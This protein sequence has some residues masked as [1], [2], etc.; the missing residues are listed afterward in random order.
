MPRV[1]IACILLLAAQVSTPQCGET[2][3]SPS[4]PSSP[5]TST[6]SPTVDVAAAPNVLAIAV[7]GGPTNSAL[8]QVFATVTICVPGTSNCQAI[9]NILVDTGSIGLRILSSALTL[10]LPQQAGPS[11]A[12]IVECHPFVDGVTWG[13]VQTAD[14][15]LS[16]E[17]ASSVPIQVLG[18]DAFP[19][20]P[21]GCSSQGPPEETQSDL[22]ANGF[23]GVGMLK[24]DCGTPCTF[25]GSSNPGLYYI[26]PTPS[27]CQ[28]T[29]EPVTSQVQNPVALFATDN[30]GVVVRL[31]IVP[32]GGA[33]SAF[34]SLIFGIGTQS[35]NQLGSAT[36][37][38]VDARQNFVTTF[39]GQSY[40]KSFID[41]GS[42]AIF[43]LDSATSGLQAC[44][45]SIGF[46]CP[47]STRALSATHVG[48]NGVS[49]V[50]AINAGDVDERNATFSAFGE[51]TGANPGGFDWGL[52][53]FYGRTIFTAIEGQPTPAGA[54]P[55]WAY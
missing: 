31:P 52:P 22:A 37:F 26:C 28:V 9:D 8:N 5:G 29:T 25:T 53:F 4:A 47:P 30:N 21:S 6:T 27:A 3:S 48:A 23:L 41:S 11:G 45:K 33:A 44:T 1:M 36:K 38:T 46:Y 13:P 51:A 49:S 19:T 54:G 32:V 16:G 20:I 50:V 15:K 7:S 10:P 55:Y 24:Q 17:V 34:G 35:N 42:N 39:N 18:V 43:F 40:P 2:G 12:P 14:I